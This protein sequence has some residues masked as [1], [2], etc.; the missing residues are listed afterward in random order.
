MM[1]KILVIEDDPA[2]RVGLY[3][4]FTNEGYS[5]TEAETGNFG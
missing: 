1:K 4:T 3:E 5:V 2:I